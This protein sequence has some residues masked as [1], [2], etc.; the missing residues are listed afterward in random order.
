MNRTK[1]SRSLSLVP[2][3]VTE[4]KGM[5]GDSE[6]VIQLM[7]VTQATSGWFGSDFVAAAVE[8]LQL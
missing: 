8:V 6:Q 2:S 5:G 7:E 4:R 1:N 3:K